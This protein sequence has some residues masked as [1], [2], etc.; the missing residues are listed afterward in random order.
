MWTV[1]VHEPPTGTS[2]GQSRGLPGVAAS[3]ACA[4]SETPRAG[5]GAGLVDLGEGTCGRRCV[6]GEV[7]AGGKEPEH[8]E[9]EP[10]VGAGAGEGE[11]P[12]RGHQPGNRRAK[13][14][15]PQSPLSPQ[16]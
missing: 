2:W 5:R 12:S 10:G 14:S 7:A 1:T 6:G 9:G 16:G 8:G 3:T 4:D 11:E 13:P 15:A